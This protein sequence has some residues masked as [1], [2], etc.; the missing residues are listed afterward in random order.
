MHFKFGQDYLEYLNA[1]SKDAQRNIVNN[2]EKDAFVYMHSTEWFNLQSHDGR[3]VALCHIL[4]LLRW[5]DNQESLDEARRSS[6]ESVDNQSGYFDTESRDHE[7][8][9][10]Y[11]DIGDD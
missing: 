7:E 6:S 9:D 3:R 2:E 5:H 1:T 8:E 11:M 4:A 10:D